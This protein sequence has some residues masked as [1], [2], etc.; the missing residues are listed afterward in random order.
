MTILGDIA[1]STGP[2]ARDDWEFVEEE[3]AGSAPLAHAELEY[4]YRVPE[5]VFAFASQLLPNV[6][7]G[8]V[9]PVIVRPGTAPRLV[10][11]TE[12]D[13]VATVVAEAREGAGRGRSV[14]VVIAPNRFD[15]VASGF[16][17]ADVRYTDGRT[18][19]VSHA[20]IVLLDAV[21]AKGLEFDAV[22]VV[23]PEEIVASDPRGH[24]LLYV[25]L[26]RCTTHLSVVHV[27]S[28]MP[29]PE[30]PAEG[31]GPTSLFPALTD[32]PEQPDLGLIVQPTDV[33]ERGGSNPVASPPASRLTA[34]LARTIA[35]EIKA[36]VDPGRWG[37]LLA[38]LN[39]ELSADEGGEDQ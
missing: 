32:R 31:S 14:G 2:W 19:K 34:A 39:S 8:I 23:E 37:E 10:P 17:E 28:A 27:G 16:D 9:P 1:Q 20:S 29:L 30:A 22:V 6:A 33:S 36:T 7:P 11:V 26:T 18:T 4:G 15:E 21:A 5:P 38:A 13:R 25:A 35:D 24:R 12:D 3:L